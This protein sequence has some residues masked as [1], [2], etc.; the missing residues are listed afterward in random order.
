MAKRLASGEGRDFKFGTQV[1]FIASQHTDYKKTVPDEL[2]GACL[3]RVTN[4]YRAM[5]W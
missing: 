2:K 3:C 1:V 4:F 5:L